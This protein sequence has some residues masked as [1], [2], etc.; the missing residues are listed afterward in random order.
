[1]KANS[2]LDYVTRPLLALLELSPV[3]TDAYSRSPPRRYRYGLYQK[4]P[5]KAAVQKEAVLAEGIIIMI[6][7]LYRGALGGPRDREGFHTLAR[8]P[9]VFR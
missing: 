9:G 8:P 6:E 4:Y 7:T 2:G 1:M 5:C 3:R